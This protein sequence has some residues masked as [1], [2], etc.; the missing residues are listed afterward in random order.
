MPKK[1]TPL[2]R[3]ELP[4]LEFWIGKPIAPGRPSRKEH[5]TAR[6]EEERLAPVSSW[7]AGINE[8]VNGDDEFIEAII[9]LRS[10]RGGVA[11][12]EVKSILGG[13]AF[14]YPKPLSLLKGLLEQSTKKGDTVLDFFAGSGTTG[15][16]LLQLNAEDGGQRH[17][18]LCSSTEANDKEPTKNICRDVC[19]ARM[20]RVIKGYNGNP[21]FTLEQGGEFAYLQ[22]DKVATADLPFEAKTENA[23][24]LLSLRLAHAVW[25]SKG[26]HIQHIAR[27]DNCDIVLCMEVTA[28]VVEELV[29]WP[30]T[31]GMQRLAV[32][33]ERPQALQEAL[34]AQGID[35]NCHSLIDALLSGQAGGRA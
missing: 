18:I 34:E 23:M 13:K 22:L 15:Q 8:E 29:A 11:T 5:W 4:D 31:H 16:A 9:T 1:K 32:Y 35:A 28:Q 3:E 19:A 26:E 14:P 6:P 21:G 12:D 10:T 25:E 30:R 24:A 27:A 17:F 2:L 33:C 20:R 7:I